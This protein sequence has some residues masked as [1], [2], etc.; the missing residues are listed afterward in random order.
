[1]GRDIQE[2]GG[3]VTNKSSKKIF[4]LSFLDRMS[5]LSIIAVLDLNVVKHAIDS[6][7]VK[8]PLDGSPS[9]EIA[10]CGKSSQ[11]K[12]KQQW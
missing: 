4:T 9:I 3:T 7:F 8:F 10:N 5:P 2:S 11:I 1:M 6:S 12:Q